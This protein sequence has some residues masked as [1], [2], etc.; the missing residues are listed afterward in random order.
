VASSVGGELWLQIGPTPTFLRGA[1][2]AVLGALLI[3]LL[4]ARR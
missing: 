3:G 4:V 1:I 2:F